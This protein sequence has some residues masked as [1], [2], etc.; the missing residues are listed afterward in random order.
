[1]KVARVW[2]IY[3][4]HIKFT[5]IGTRYMTFR[6]KEMPMSDIKIS[7]TKLTWLPVINKVN[8]FKRK[9]IFSY[10]SKYPKDFTYILLILLYLRSLIE[11]QW[12]DLHV[13]LNFMHFSNF[14][15]YDEIF[16][17]IDLK[18]LLF[19]TSS[20]YSLLYCDVLMTLCSCTFD[21]TVDQ[22]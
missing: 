9:P 20:V 12:L 22:V 14:P 19:I 5:H 10:H 4:I 7:K 2:M 8:K 3:S 15:Y 1:M 11:Y 16:T 6:G 17:I 13:L 21:Y 18:E